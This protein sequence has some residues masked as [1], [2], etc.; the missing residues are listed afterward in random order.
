MSL[1]L[2]AAF[3][4]LAWYAAIDLAARRP[5][6][7]DFECPLY[8]PVPANPADLGKARK[9]EG[10]RSWSAGAG[11][12]AMA[13]GLVEAAW[14]LRK[15]RAE[16]LEH[17]LP[18]VD[19]LRSILV[20]LAGEPIE[21]QGHARRVRLE[22]VIARGSGARRLDAVRAGDRARTWL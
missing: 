18:H 17:E 3:L 4:A 16:A 8:V 20:E 12:G 1:P 14:V 19:R 11:S 15:L 9:N 5:V 21:E 2:S 10:N 22:L 13:T 7:L 6:A